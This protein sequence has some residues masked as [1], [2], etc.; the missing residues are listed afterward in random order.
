MSF[1]E[2]L[3]KKLKRVLQNLNET[4]IEELDVWLGFLP[5]CDYQGIRAGQ[6]AL[7]EPPSNQRVMVIGF[8]TNYVKES[9]IDKAKKNELE[10]VTLTMKY[11]PKSKAI[12]MF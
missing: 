6:Y 5:G 1:K 2:I 8:S 10:D 3:E 4:N 7:T 9:G 11:T 12:C